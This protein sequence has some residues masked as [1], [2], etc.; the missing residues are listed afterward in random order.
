VQGSLISIVL[1]VHN[2]GDHICCLVES[3]RA[4][5]AAQVVIPFEIVLVTNACTDSSPQMCQALAARYATSKPSIF[6]KAR[7]GVALFESRTEERYRRSAVLYEFCRLRPT[8]YCG[9]K[10][11]HLQSEQRHQSQSEDP[12]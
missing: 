2:Q 4:A 12:R 8:S 10:I 5:L 6:R 1:P 9:D 7:L 3:Y 11:C